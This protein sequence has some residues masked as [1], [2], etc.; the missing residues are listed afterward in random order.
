MTVVHFRCASQHVRTRICQT[1]TTVSKCCSLRGQLVV[2]CLGQTQTLDTLAAPCQ[3]ST[4]QWPAED[5]VHQQPVQWL[6]RFVLRL[7]LRTLCHS[8]LRH[9]VIVV[10]LL[11]VIQEVER[12]LLLNEL[13]DKVDVH[14]SKMTVSLESP[15][16]HTEDGQVARLELAWKLN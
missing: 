6:Q 9:C 3:I 13:Q 10:W 4:Q 2:D 1:Q 16:S 11:I 12:V 8:S 7:N 14:Q 5:T 15:T